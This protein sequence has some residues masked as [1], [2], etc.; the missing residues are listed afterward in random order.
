LKIFGNQVARIATHNGQIISTAW[1]ESIKVMN[2]DLKII[3]EYPGLENLRCRA[4]DVNDNFIALGASNGNILV[5]KRGKQYVRRLYAEHNANITRLEWNKLDNLQLLVSCSLNI[6]KVWNPDHSESIRTYTEH[7][8]TVNHID[9]IKLP[10]LTES[11]VI[12]CSNDGSC[13]IWDINETNSIHSLHHRQS[14]CLKFTINQ[15]HD[16]LVIATQRGVAVWSLEDLDL[17][18][19]MTRFNDTIDVQ[20][21][22]DGSKL[23]LFQVSFMLTKNKTSL[24]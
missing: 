19:L 13:K 15:R 5:I 12:S 7:K 18:K 14:P 1:Q 20:F 21:N 23:A 16:L 3:E 4:I 6:V 24:F 11:S 10:G 8:S 9:W 22:Q 2:T 17:I